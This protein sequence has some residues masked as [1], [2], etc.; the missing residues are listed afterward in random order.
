MAVAAFTYSMRNHNLIAQVWGKNK[1]TQ[2]LETIID[3]QTK[4]EEIKKK[5][6]AMNKEE[7]GENQNRT[8]CGRNKKKKIQQKQKGRD[9]A[10]EEMQEMQ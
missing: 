3:G 5:I 10:G 2:E 9:S 8:C 4:T 1:T 7:I 6:Q